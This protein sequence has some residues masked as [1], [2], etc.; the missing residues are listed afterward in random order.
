MSCVLPMA[1]GLVRMIPVGAQILHATGPL[2]SFEVASIRL[3]PVQLLSPS[4]NGGTAPNG[5]QIISQQTFQSEGPARAGPI[6][7]PTKCASL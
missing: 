4:P 1:F 2:P 3:S 7:L 6:S 5:E